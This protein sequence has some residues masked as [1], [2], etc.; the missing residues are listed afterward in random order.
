MRSV[1]MGLVQGLVMVAILVWTVGLDINNLGG[2]IW[3]VLLTS[4]TYYAINQAL[5]AL[6]GPPGRFLALILTAVQLASA[7]GTYPIETSPGFF[8]AMHP[9]L[10]LTYAVEAFRSFIAGGDIGVAHGVTVMTVWAVIGLLLLWL[11]AFIR[12]RKERRA[13]AGSAEGPRKLVKA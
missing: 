6:L 10:P 5:V 3:F 9:W 7:G 12:Q 8:Q 1:L 4:V 11:A 13:W 2:L